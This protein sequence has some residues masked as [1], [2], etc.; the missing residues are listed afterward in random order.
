MTTFTVELPLAAVAGDAAVAG[1]AAARPRVAV[2]GTG[3][4]GAAMARN[5]LRA[6]L[7][8][9]AWTRT[10]GRTRPL[11]ELGATSHPTPASHR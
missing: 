8:V 10:P 7:P 6:G 3:T 9:A 4:M 1:E 2:I 5:L 11:T